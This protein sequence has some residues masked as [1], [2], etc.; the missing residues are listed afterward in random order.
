M[1]SPPSV[2]AISSSLCRTRLTADPANRAEDMVKNAA[3]TILALGEHSFAD[4]GTDFATVAAGV[5]ARSEAAQGDKEHRRL[6][7]G[8]PAV[9]RL[10]GGLW[11][12]E[13][14]YRMA[15]S[16]TGKSPEHVHVFRLEMTAEGLIKTNLASTTR[17]SADQIKSGQIDNWIEYERGRQ[18]SDQPEPGCSRSHRR[19]ARPL[20][21]QRVDRPTSPITT[22]ELSRATNPP[23]P[24]ST[25][26]LI[27]AAAELITDAT[28]RHVRSLTPTLPCRRCCE[29][30]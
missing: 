16:R 7:T 26:W 30:V 5:V 20:G 14:Y 8:I 18:A 19:A 2:Q 11:P 24:P 28:L 13:L 27:G 23:H 4:R 15:R 12:G 3:E 22:L 10:W 29:Y 6:D 21:Y 17:W 1:L 25:G 9:D